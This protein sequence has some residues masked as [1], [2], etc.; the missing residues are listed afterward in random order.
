MLCRIYRIDSSLVSS[1]YPTLILPSTQRI[2]DALNDFNVS[3][4]LCPLPHPLISTA[5][6]TQ[7]WFCLKIL[8]FILLFFNYYILL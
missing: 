8:Y 6:P 2:E 7:Q 3:N 5:V 1:F 4:D